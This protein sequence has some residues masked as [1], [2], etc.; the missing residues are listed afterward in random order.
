VARGTTRAKAGTS[1]PPTQARV[2]STA[3]TPQGTGRKVRIR[4]AGASTATSGRSTRFAATAQRG[5]PP[6]NRAS[7]GRVESQGAPARARNPAGFAPRGPRRPAKGAEP[8]SSPARASQDSRKPGSHP[9]AGWT[10]NHASRAPWRVTT[11]GSFHP[12]PLPAAQ[13]APMR[14]PRHTGALK[15]TRTQ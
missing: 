10:R 2:P 5:A 11:G 6:W 4:Q 8:H 13:A 7:S 12:D 1:D 14:K 9:A 15:P 3:A